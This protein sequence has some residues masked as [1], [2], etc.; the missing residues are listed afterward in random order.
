MTSE[1]YKKIIK[2]L[3]EEVEDLLDENKEMMLENTKL[4]DEADSLWSMMDEM[5]E[6]D[7]KNYSH[8]LKD[9]KSDILTR[10][11]MITTKKADA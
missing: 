9:V 11:L 6:A 5:T 2:E 8:L 4:Q 10:T 1:E 3:K 7:I